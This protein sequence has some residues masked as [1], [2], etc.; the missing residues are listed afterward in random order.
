MRT[1]RVYRAI[2]WYAGL[3][4]GE[5]AVTRHFHTRR[6][7][8]NWAEGRRKGFPEVPGTVYLGQGE[9]DD[10]PALEPALRVEVADSEPVV[11]P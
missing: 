4:D 2:A 7:R 10:R 1:R 6:A 5:Y 11:F 8:D 9:Y 3:P